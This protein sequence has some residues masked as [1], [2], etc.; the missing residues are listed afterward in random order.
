ML[1][2]LMLIVGIRLFLLYKCWQK[3]KQHAQKIK[4]HEDQLKIKGSEL[5]EK[6]AEN[7]YLTVKAYENLFFKLIGIYR[8]NFTF[9]R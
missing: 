6:K 5:Q 7:R 1:L 2:F 9:F 3:E 4:S 8:F